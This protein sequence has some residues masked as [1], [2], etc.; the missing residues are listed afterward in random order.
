M[1]NLLIVSF[2]SNI[3][4]CG[5][6]VFISIRK[7]RIIEKPVIVETRVD[8]IVDI[9]IIEKEEVKIDKFKHILDPEEK[10][11][12]EYRCGLGVK[13]EVASREFHGYI[14]P[15]QTNELMNIEEQV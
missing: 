1:I 11:Y 14:E 7:T 10:S 3:I 8:S 6:I 9:P 13:E 5:F 12:L 4:L 2:I 15:S